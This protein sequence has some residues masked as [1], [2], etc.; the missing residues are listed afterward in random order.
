M[1]SVALAGNGQP[2][3]TFG[4]IADREAHKFM[5][6]NG[7]VG[8]AI[9][10]CKKGKTQMRFYG[11]TDKEKN[12]KP[13]P[14]SI[15]NIASISKTFTGLLLAS[16]ALEQKVNVNDDVRMYL[17]EPYPNLEYGGQPILL[18]HLVS[19]L[20]RLPSSL[21]DQ[22]ESPGY[23]KA[24]F[25]KDLHNVKLDTLPGLRFM[26]SNAALQLLG[27]I[28][29]DVYNTSLEALLKE[30]ITG[31]LKMKHTS[32][33]LQDSDKKLKTKGYNEDGKENADL[34]DRLAGAG[35]MKSTM[36]DLLKYVAFQL[37]EATG[38]MKLSHQEIW[39]FDMN[40]NTRYSFSMGWQTITTKDGHRRIFQ[41][42][43]LHSYTCVV[44]FSPELQTGIVVLSNSL[45]T[46]AGELANSILK[47]MEPRMP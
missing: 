9:G 45:M 18:K 38:V 42:G 10:I 8:L 31:P 22:S 15:F 41:D 1:I 43:N 34:Y 20:S 26:Y 44:I 47:E 27:Y 23:S 11:T 32:I 16:A 29:E 35:G 25:F 13:T 28:L 6:S 39:G 40:D 5:V 19:H 36:E 17:R 33:A 7:A 24:D 4:T 21:S 3:D 2:V 46:G 37:D 30:K 12:D 14:R